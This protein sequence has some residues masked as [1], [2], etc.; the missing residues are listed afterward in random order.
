MKIQLKLTSSKNYFL[1]QLIAVFLEIDNQIANMT[2]ASVTYYNICTPAMIF[3][4][5][6]FFVASYIHR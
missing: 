2:L 6:F 1:R 3:F 5:R 4:L